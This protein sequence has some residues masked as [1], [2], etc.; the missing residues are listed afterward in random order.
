[1]ILLGSLNHG[2]YNR[3]DM[4]LRWGIRNAYEMLSEKLIRIC[5]LGSLR[6]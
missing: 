2:R 5:P 1:M 6:R 3:L 4:Q